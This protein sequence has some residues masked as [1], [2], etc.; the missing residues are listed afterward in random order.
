MHFLVARETYKA[1]PTDLRA[2]IR[3]YLS[4]Y[5]FGA[6]GADFC[7]FYKLTNAGK[8]NLG[9]Y[10]HRK[11]GFDAFRLLK[12]LSAY[13][14]QLYAYALGYI[15][16]YA[17]DTLF[18]P[19]VYAVSGKSLLLHS[20]VEGAMDSLYL[21]LFSPVKQ[22]P[23]YTYFRKKLTEKES[24]ELFFFYA[25]ISEQAGFP[26][27]IKSYFLRSISTFNTYAPLSFSV[28]GEK[29]PALVHAVFGNKNT[30]EEAKRLFKLAVENAVFLCE[31][32]SSA[33]ESISKELFGKNYLTGK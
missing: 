20:R 25:A 16:H 4:L 29:R 19:F 22:K 2:K 11:G 21:K 9:S 14:P 17:V 8:R 13:S 15:T 27:L 1:L 6:Q 12:S 7:F 33:N 5:F 31:Q 28:F 10:L 24:N 18:H 3:P 32:F 30:N 26:T 23:Y